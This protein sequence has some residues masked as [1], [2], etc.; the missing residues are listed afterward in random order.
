MREYVLIMN[1]YN[2]GAVA[3]LTDQVGR[4]DSSFLL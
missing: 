4:S 2:N 1:I 3:Q